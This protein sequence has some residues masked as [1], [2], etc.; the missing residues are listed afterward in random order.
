M[1]M[2][3][4]S[5]CKL[6]T[7]RPESEKKDCEDDPDGEHRLVEETSERGMETVKGPGSLEM[8]MTTMGGS[9]R[10]GVWVDEEYVGSGRS[11]ELRRGPEGTFSGLDRRSDGLAVPSGEA[12]GGTEIG[13][14]DSPNP[15]HEAALTLA[16]VGSKHVTRGALQGLVEEA[17]HSF[18][19]TPSSNVH[20]PYFETVSRFH[21]S[22][23]RESDADYL[24]VIADGVLNS[25]VSLTNDPLDGRLAEVIAER[26]RLF[27]ASFLNEESGEVAGA[28]TSGE[29]PE[30]FEEEVADV[31]IVAFGIAEAFGFDPLE[32]FEAKMEENDTKPK[33]QNGSGK[34]PSEARQ[35][36]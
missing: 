21:D 30:D 29:T 26:N 27:W 35:Q 7:N 5:E 15:E 17:A 4:C 24:A 20:D 14:D 10:I 23:R 12:P 22:L 9:N 16:G 8:H 28:L 31:L 18:K 34:L 36:W 11:M 33:E 25:D 19:V 6:R 1:T 2:Y 3:T 32:A 13:L